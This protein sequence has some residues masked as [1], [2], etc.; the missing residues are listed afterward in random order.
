MIAKYNNLKVEII[1]ENKYDYLIQLGKKVYECFTIND[2]LRSF[3]TIFN[4]E[5][6][7]NL[8]KHLLKNKFYKWVHKKEIVFYRLVMET[9]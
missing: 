5:Q 7:Y 3:E 6:F 4:Y 8:K 1:G 9:E 2:V